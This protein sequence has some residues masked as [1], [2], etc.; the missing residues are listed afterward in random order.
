MLRDSRTYLVITAAFAIGTL[1]GFA[2]HPS[3]ASAQDKTKYMGDVIFR[4]S[5]MVPQATTWDAARLLM[6]CR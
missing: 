2:V 3:S 6:C 1:V 4:K 5:V